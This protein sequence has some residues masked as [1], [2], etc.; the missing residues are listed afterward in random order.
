ML[1]KKINAVST[2]ATVIPAVSAESAGEQTFLS[3]IDRP[4]AKGWTERSQTTGNVLH[5]VRPGQLQ[6]SSTPKN[7]PSLDVQLGCELGTTKATTHDLHRL[8]TN[9]TI[10]WALGRWMDASFCT[11]YVLSSFIQVRP[12]ICHP[13]VCV[14]VLLKCLNYLTGFALYLAH[15][16]L[17]TWVFVL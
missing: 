1:K 7:I 4:I 6:C 11:P 3:L 5:R 15:S 17:S 2:E 13:C 10:Q 14:C 12:V 9:Q 16:P 8:H